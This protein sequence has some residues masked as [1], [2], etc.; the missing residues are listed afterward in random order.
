MTHAAKSEDI[1]DIMLS[2]VHQKPEPKLPFLTLITFN[3]RNNFEY[4]FSG[5]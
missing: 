1:P 4:K 5:E 3:V 2:F